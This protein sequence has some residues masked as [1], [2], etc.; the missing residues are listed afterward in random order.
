MQFNTRV[1]SARW[2]D[3]SRSWL[4]LDSD[5]NKYTSRF[6]VTCMGILNE[7]TYPNIPGLDTYKGAAFHTARWPK[8]PVSLEGKRVGI[9]GTGATGIQIIQEIV[10][11]V[12]HLTVFQRT[13]NWSAPLH[14]SKI[15]SEE[16]DAIRKQYPEIF[17]QC[18]DSYS[19]FIHGAD[20][21][22]TFDVPE[23]ERLAFWE[24]LYSRPGFA[25]WLS[26]F[27]DINF[28]QKANDA[29]SEF[30]AN[31]IRQ[32]VKEPATAEKLIPKNHGFGTRRVPLET[33]YFEAYNRDNVR[34]VDISEDPIECITETG[35]KTRD[36]EFPL[37]VLIY[38]TGF[39]A[40]TGAFNAVDFQ[41]MNGTKLTDTWSEGP[42]TFLGLL[43]KDFPNMMM[44][45]GPHQMFGNIP[46]SIEY[47]VGW[48]ADCIRFCS[49]RSITRIEAT[50]KGV[51]E[52]T[53]HV[54]NCAQGLLANN[55]D[56][57]MTGVNKNLAHKQKRIIARYQGPAPGYRKLAGSVAIRNYEDLALA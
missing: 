11:T 16:M 50:D 2:Q 26:N 5:G 36:E 19:C 7:P 53:D 13:P 55:V 40:V 4:L 35:I 29:F 18:S 12:G 30:I 41:G 39:D 52:W 43:V 32:R 37:D 24:H 14:N 48:V 42:R 34:L 20:T 15:S 56:S 44:V 45:M 17:R 22:K 31:K 6:L 23:E 28:D 9:I 46:R 21:R 10:K 47:A 54:H 8:E 27:G 51:E 38:A 1:K 49:E 57:W 3:T 33:H 25:K